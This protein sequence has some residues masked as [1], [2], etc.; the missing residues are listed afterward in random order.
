VALAA[1]L[2]GKADTR[3]Q[4]SVIILTGGN[5]DEDLFSRI[6]AQAI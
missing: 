1:L 4:T 6:L 3:D 5:V 2:A